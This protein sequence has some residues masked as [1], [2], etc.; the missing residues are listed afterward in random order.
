MPSCRPG[1]LAALFL[2]AFPLCVRAA[3]FSIAKADAYDTPK[4]QRIVDLTLVAG[5]NVKVDPTQL[6]I[7]TLF[8]ARAKDG[9]ASPAYPTSRVNW[10][11]TPVDWASKSAAFQVEFPALDWSADN[12]PLGVVVGIYYRHTLQ[13]TWSFPPQLAK[14]FP[15][16]ARDDQAP[17]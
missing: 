15:L 4:H 12:A 5:P 14:D 2:L 11:N 17:R 13:T 6:S 8:Y 3:E 9:S 7:T 16:P 1:H 10:L